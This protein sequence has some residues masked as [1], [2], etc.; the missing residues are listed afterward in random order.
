M[1]NRIIEANQLPENEKV[2]LRKGFNGWKVIHPIK[3][4]DGSTNWKNLICGGSWWNLI[5]MIVF[6]LVAI[7]FFFEYHSN[8]KH[9][10]DI[11]SQMNNETLSLKKVIIWN[12]KNP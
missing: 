6:V 1:D 2:Y 9:C 4:D 12:L 7:G 3:N 10:A 8:L 11:M 5:I